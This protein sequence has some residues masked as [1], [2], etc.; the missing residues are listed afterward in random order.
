MLRDWVR[1]A[2]FLKWKKFYLIPKLERWGW[3]SMKWTR[4]ALSS[5][6]GSSLHSSAARSS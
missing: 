4:H 5:P 3:L 2:L 6:M 1:L